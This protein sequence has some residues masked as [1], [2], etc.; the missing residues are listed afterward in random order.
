MKLEHARAIEDAAGSI[1]LDVELY[2]GYSGRCMYG[3]ETTGVVGD[4]KDIICAIAHAANQMGYDR[5]YLGEEYNDD[6]SFLDGIKHIRFDNMG[7]S[8][9][10]VY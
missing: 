10:I 8:R 1:G 4:L 5:G 7:R 3:E 9:D 2:E 6:E